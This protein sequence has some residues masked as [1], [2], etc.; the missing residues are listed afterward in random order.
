MKVFWTR[1]ILALFLS[2]FLAGCVASLNPLYDENNKGGFADPTPYLG[3]WKNT[4]WSFRIH[5]RD[6][7]EL[8]KRPF[9]IAVLEKVLPIHGASPDA[10]EPPVRAAVMTGGIVKIED[11]EFLDLTMDINANASL[12]HDMAPTLFVQMIPV[13]AFFKFKLENDEL[14]LLA[15]DPKK[16]GALLEREPTAVERVKSYGKKESGPSG[17]LL[18]SSSP[19][20]LREFLRKYGAT[21]IWM[22][23]DSKV[24][25]FT[26]G[27]DKEFDATWAELTKR[28]NQLESRETRRPSPGATTRPRK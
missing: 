23:P 15:L 6:R 18:L 26:R 11:Q 14:T 24:T 12:L 27:D 7:V 17:G 2:M 3:V 4:R 22:D 13:H 19:A 5:E 9:T 20:E 8:R 16:V 1:S 25:K 10:P 28:L 21:N